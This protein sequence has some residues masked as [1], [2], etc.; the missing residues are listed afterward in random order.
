MLSTPGPDHPV[1]APAATAALRRDAAHAVARVAL[2]LAA[3]SAAA[4]LVVPLEGLSL[5]LVPKALLCFGVA[6][7]LM[8]AGL[9]A[10]APHA[11]FGAANGITLGRL[12]LIALLAA[13]LGETPADTGAFGWTVV[14][15][16]TVAAL[17]DAVDGPVARRRQEAS[18]FGARFDME[19]DA[20]LI[21]VL[22][23]LV[24]QLDKA[25]AWVLASGAMRY[26]FVAAAW[27]WPW[28]AGP[29][30]PSL[31]RKAV[32]VTQITTLILCLGPIV[33]P[34]LS[35]VIAAIGLVALAWSFFVDLRWLARHRPRILEAGT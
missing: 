19:T 27:R 33:D 1:A 12:A 23:A 11:R 28:L 15:L 13:S 30:P 17:L 9:A 20:L 14:V 22:S 8:W 16:A 4:A 21:L 18:A 5:W 3:G 34:R 25:G 10:H 31:R 35:R 7:M 26:A 6:A 2:G 32:C 24:L 29:L